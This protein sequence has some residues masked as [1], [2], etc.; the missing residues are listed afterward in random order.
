M[1]ILMMGTTK[2]CISVFSYQLG[3][4]AGYDKIGDEQNAQ[5]GAC[6][7]FLAVSWIRLYDQYPDYA[8]LKFTF[9]LSVCLHDE[10]GDGFQAI[11]AQDYS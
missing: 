10:A 3:G 9:P 6:S 8:F 11:M 2:Y 4:H 7:S 1:T 5:H